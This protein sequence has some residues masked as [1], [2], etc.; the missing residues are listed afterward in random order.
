[1]PHTEC[2]VAF[3][4]FVTNREQQG[5]VPK[6]VSRLGNSEPFFRPLHF[7]IENFTIWEIAGGMVPKQAGTRSVGG[8][9]NRFCVGFRPLREQGRFASQ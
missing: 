9:E 3:V 4:M 6:K 5:R 8:P 2:Q 1:M 7:G